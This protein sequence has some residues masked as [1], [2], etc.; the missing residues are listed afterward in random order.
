MKSIPVTDR[1]GKI[2]YWIGDDTPDTTHP[3]FWLKGEN[4]LGEWL[5]HDG[6]AWIPSRTGELIAFYEGS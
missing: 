3:K 4:G 1:T 2:H 6:T 5:K